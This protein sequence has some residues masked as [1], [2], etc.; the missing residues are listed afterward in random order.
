MELELSHDVEALRRRVSDLE[1]EKSTAYADGFVAGLKE[2]AYWKDGTQWV[3]TCGKT[4]SCAI[5]EFL[6]QRTVP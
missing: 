5:E 4:L 6:A 1:A 2:F 3:G